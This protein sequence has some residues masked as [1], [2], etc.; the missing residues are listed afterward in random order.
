MRKYVN[1][2]FALL[3]FTFSFSVC[4]F[5]DMGPKP[6]VNVEFTGGQGK[7]YYVTLLSEN[8]S[9]GPYY[10]AKQGD[11]MQNKPS[12]IISAAEKFEEYKDEDGYYFIQYVENCTERNLKYWCIFPKQILMP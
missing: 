5:A 8:D 9:T 7:E 1:F 4:A 10:T 6:S 3:L 2:I 12:N 11:I